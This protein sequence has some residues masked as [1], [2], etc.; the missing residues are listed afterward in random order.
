MNIK[1]RS[2]TGLILM[3]ILIALTAF[4]LASAICIRVFA[5][6]NLLSLQSSKQNY[7]TRVAQNIEACIRAQGCE[8][9][10]NLVIFYGCAN[11]YGNGFILA[12]A[13]KLNVRIIYSDEGNIRTIHYILTEE[14]PREELFPEDILGEYEIK[15]LKR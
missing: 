6:A 10:E 14:D 15:C 1:G 4:A 12:K 2:R 8:D 13:N 3:E 9:L 5:T 7:A 11:D